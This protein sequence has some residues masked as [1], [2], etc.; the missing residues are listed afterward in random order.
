[1]N[2]YGQR[3]ILKKIDQ[4]LDNK[5]LIL[6]RDKPFV[7]VS[8]LEAGEGVTT[9]AHYIASTLYHN[10]MI[11]VEG[12]LNILEYK[13]DGSL[14]QLEDMIDDID[15]CAV[16]T[17]YFAGV[18][19]IDLESLQD[20]YDEYQ[21]SYII[22]YINQRAQYTTYII[23]A[24]SKNRKDNRLLKR[25]LNE[26]DGAIYLESTFYSAIEYASIIMENIL[27]NNIKIDDEKE[28][29]NYIVQEIQQENLEGLKTVRNHFEFL[30]KCLKCENDFYTLNVKLVKSYIDSR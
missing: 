2:I 19:C 15:D 21:T 8:D 7:F 25:L 23:L 26:I 1:M 20:Y 18:V 9:I 13:V 11:K 6:F 17:N 10:K 30:Y 3:K 28:L 27:R 16:Y 12:D 14:K 29:K 5:N 22:K 24:A 4:L